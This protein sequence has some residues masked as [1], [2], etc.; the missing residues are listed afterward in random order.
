[1]YEVDICSDNKYYLIKNII[2]NNIVLKINKEESL[3]KA[4]KLF[5]KKHKLGGY[6]NV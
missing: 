6:K 5:M 4:L 1:M 2:N 3:E